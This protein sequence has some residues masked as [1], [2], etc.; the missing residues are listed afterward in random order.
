MECWFLG[1]DI[2]FTSYEVAPVMYYKDP[3]NQY[4]DAYDFPVLNA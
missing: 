3:F 4:D 2:A 1:K